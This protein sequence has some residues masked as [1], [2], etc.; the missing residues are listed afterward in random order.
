MTLHLLAHQPELVAREVVGRHVVVSAAAAPG[1]HQPV[2]A[3]DVE[4]ARRA[5]GQG[6]EVRDR[7]HHATVRAHHPRHL[8]DRALGLVE[9][10]EG[11]LAER[12][13][14]ARVG[15][16]ESMAPSLHPARR[17]ASGL[18]LLPVDEPRPAEHARRRLRADR[19]RAARRERPRVLPE[20]ARDVEHARAGPWAR[21][22]ER[23]L[24]HLVEEVLAVARGPGRNH[25]AHVPVEVDDAHGGAQ[26]SLATGLGERTSRSEFASGLRAR[27]LRGG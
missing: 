24:R 21:E 12:G 8:R 5:T 4:R 26:G 3:Y 25:V 27:A 18:A 7:E 2:L 11:A 14:E 13:V 22:R 23:P 16:G 17:R 19:E 9:V 15:K 10:V 6:L 1:P 20:A